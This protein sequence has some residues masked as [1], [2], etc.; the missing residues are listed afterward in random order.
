MII[1]TTRGER[2]RWEAKVGG[3]GKKSGGEMLSVIS[4]TRG[5]AEKCDIAL[6]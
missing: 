4:V 1:L 2:K 6:D 3:G 5:E